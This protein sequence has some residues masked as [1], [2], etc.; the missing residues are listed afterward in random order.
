[1]KNTMWKFARQHWLLILSLIYILSPIDFIPE[2]F[3]GPIGLIDD[4]GL[5]TFLIFYEAIK[6][7]YN[8][9]IE[10]GYKELK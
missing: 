2:A 1:M 8:Q 5:V 3:L 7:I 9:R 6:F 10:K 4:L